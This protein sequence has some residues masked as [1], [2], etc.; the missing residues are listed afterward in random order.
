VERRN[1]GITAELTNATSNA[2]A[3][4]TDSTSRA[5]AQAQRRMVGYDVAARC[6]DLW[7]SAQDRVFGIGSGDVAEKVI[8]HEKIQRVERGMDPP[9]AG[10]MADDAGY[11]IG[12]LT[13]MEK[14]QKLAP[15]CSLE[16]YFS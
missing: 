3:V 14:N 12:V 13:G 11:V 15:C 9:L 4:H 10:A 5:K 1:G 7:I 2:F 8:H 6:L 16:V